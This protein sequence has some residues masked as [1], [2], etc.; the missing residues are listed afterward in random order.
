[1]HGTPLPNIE[2]DKGSRRPDLEIERERYKIMRPCTK[3]GV[4]PVMLE[5]WLH[6]TVSN[7]YTRNAL[8]EGHL[9]LLK[10]L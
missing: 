4:E 1:M 10:F 6:T 8:A 3:V 7:N 2:H 9:N 5:Y